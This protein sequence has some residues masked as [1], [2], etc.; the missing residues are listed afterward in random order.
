[1]GEIP[2]RYAVLALKNP[3]ARISCV[4]LFDDLEVFGGQDREVDSGVVTLQVAVS[5]EPAAGRST[6]VVGTRPQTCDSALNPC[7]VVLGVCE[8]EEQVCITFSEA[9]WW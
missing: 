7:G 1:M 4:R 2:L 9:V 3:K 6:P 5:G 8:G